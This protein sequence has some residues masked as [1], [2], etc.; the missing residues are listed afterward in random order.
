MEV[1]ITINPEANNKV[2]H[3]G[4]IAVFDDYSV[5]NDI[6]NFKGYD[7]MLV[8]SN[9][10]DK[11]EMPKSM[12]SLEVNSVISLTSLTDTKGML[13]LHIDGEGDEYFSFN[14]NEKLF[15]TEIKPFQSVQIPLFFSHKEP[16]FY[17]SH[18]TIHFNIEMTINDLTRKFDFVLFD[19]LV[20]CQ[21]NS[22][23]LNFSSP[24]IDFDSVSIDSSSTKAIR[25][26]SESNTF[27]YTAISFPSNFSSSVDVLEADTNIKNEAY[28]KTL[29]ITFTPTESKTY[30]DTLFLSTLN[31]T[32]SIR[33]YGFAGYEV[34][35]YIYYS[36]F[37]CICIVN[38]IKL[39]TSTSIRSFSFKYYQFWCF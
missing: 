37:I 10:K 5:L 36:L 14:E 23:T 12:P 25:I 34:Y 3:R 1:Q 35:T 27:P 13:N 22:F 8:V 17:E 16:G 21:V 39:W 31:Q 7:N 30:C 24:I 32:Y 4:Y 6:Y 19:G 18:L 2:I 38:N 20:T 28:Q 29:S 15:C 11:F 26:T 9:L 33:L